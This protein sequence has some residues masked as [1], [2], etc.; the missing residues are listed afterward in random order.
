M[1][2]AFRDDAKFLFGNME[3]TEKNKSLHRFQASF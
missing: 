1:A 2:A 3:K